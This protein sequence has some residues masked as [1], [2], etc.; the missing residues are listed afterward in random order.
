MDIKKLLKDAYKEDMT[1]EELVKALEGVEFVDN[2][3]EIEKLKNALSKS[4]SE[5]ADYKRQLREKMSDDERKVKEVEDAQAKLLEELEALRKKDK[6][7]TSKA[8][9]LTLGYS[10]ELATSAAEAFV[11]GNMDA[12]FD[13]QKKYTESLSK[14]IKADLI[15][16]TPTPEKKDGGD[17]PITKDMLGKMNP[18]ERHKFSLEH[19]DEYKEIYGGK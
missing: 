18:I 16:D 17:N 6:L 19:P 7:S 12:V 15:K 8:R 13:I 4:N 5:A 1:A 10:E 3:H 9:F 11:D 14:K 2:S